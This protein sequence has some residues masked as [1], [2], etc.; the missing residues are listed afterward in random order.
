MKIYKKNKAFTLAEMM[1]SF[2]MVAA[3][4]SLLIGTFK[5]SG[6]QENIL[7]YRKTFT[8]LQQA[9][10]QLANDREIFP[11]ENLVFMI[12][13]RRN[14]DGS[15][16]HTMEQ[17]C[18]EDDPATA[19]IDES[20]IC[21]PTD[22]YEL[23]PSSKFFCSELIR[24]INI[25]QTPAR[26][27]L[28]ATPTCEGEANMDAPNLNITMANGVQL[29]NVS[30][31]TFEGADDD[32]YI[33]NHIDIIIDTNGRKGPNSLA[34]TDKRDRFRLRI[35]FDGKV[36]T[37]ASWTAENAIFRAGTKAQTLKLGT[38]PDEE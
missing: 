18:Q 9:I 4:T 32:A 26:N 20:D 21:I 16:A 38:L 29:F 6:P 2:I 36:T 30:E 33:S 11:D 12:N 35:D 7:N 1:V 14:A 37:D 19:D 3:I 13:A 17:D 10:S 22:E 24:V 15:Y 8:T 27:G 31:N 25:L 28:P 23:N 34:A 5:D